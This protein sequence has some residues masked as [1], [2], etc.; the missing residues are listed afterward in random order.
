VLSQLTEA[1]I[2]NGVPYQR[3]GL[4]VYRFGATD[5]FTVVR[6]GGFARVHR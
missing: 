5:K 1:M 6:F 2:V 3:G 4:P